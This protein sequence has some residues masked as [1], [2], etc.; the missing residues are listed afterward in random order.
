MLIVE[1]DQDQYKNS[2][3]LVYKYWYR[4]QGSGESTEGKHDYKRVPI[5]IRLVN[6]VMHKVYAVDP[7]YSRAHNLLNV[8]TNIAELSP[9][10][11]K[12]FLTNMMVG[13]ILDWFYGDLSKYW[14]NFNDLSNIPIFQTNIECFIP[15]IEP[16]SFLSDFDEDGGDSYQSSCFAEQYYTHFYKLIS[17]LV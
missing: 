7:K 16:V 2:G 6:C 13:K 3:V 10:I 11:R 8:L 15:K 17:C 5:I 9:V 4:N 14:G 12:Y 1:E